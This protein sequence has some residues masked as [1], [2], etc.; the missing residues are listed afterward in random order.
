MTKL[1][2]LRDARATEIETAK[3]ITA[4]AKEEDRDLTDEELAKVN[5]HVARSKQLGEEIDAEGA[6]GLDSR[7]FRARLDNEVSLHEGSGLVFTDAATGRTVRALQPGERF[8]S[9]PIDD[10]QPHF[11]GRS[12]HS[13]LTGRMDNAPRGLQLGGSDTGGGFLL[14]P[15]LSE[16]VIDLA[17]ANSVCLKAGAQTITMESNELNLVRV[18]SDPTPMWRPEGSS[19]TASGMTFGRITLRSHTLAAIIPITLELL[20]DSGNAAGVIEDCVS[21]AIAS[22]IDR[23]SLVGAGSASE[24][25]GLRNTT[26]VNTVT[27]IGTP[28]S[29]VHLASAVGEILADNYSGDLGA[30][31]WVA[32]PVDGEVYAK[33]CDTTGQPMMPGPWVAPLKKFYTTT[34]PQDEGS[35]TDSAMFVGDFREMLLG[36]RRSGVVIRRIPAGT[37]TDSAGT[38][39]NAV[40]QL[41]EHLVVHTRV[42][43]ALMRPSWFCL[44]TGLVTS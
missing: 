21:R 26:G 35:G 12:I 6:G 4:K 18:D 23:V 9:K 42:D 20:E 1:E 24:P 11:V 33:L 27:S 25:L 28:T 40:N 16:M 38:S 8:C 5:G 31:S 37:V 15:Q 39:Y 34:C 17:R 44:L 7:R 29:Y 10:G 19:V 3:A 32:H 13:W 30:L 41:L 43:V 14:Q 36:V 22:E 2:L